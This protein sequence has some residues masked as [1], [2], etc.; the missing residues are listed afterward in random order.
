MNSIRVKVVTVL[1]LLLVATSFALQS[2][3]A[4]GMMKSSR[5][6]DMRF[7]MMARRLNLTDSQ[8][9]AIKPIYDAHIAQMRSHY[10]QARENFQSVL[11]PA[12][13]ARLHEMKLKMQEDLRTGRRIS[14]RGGFK[15]IGLT[16][17]QKAKLREMRKAGF[18][19]MKAERKAYFSRVEQ[20]LNANQQGRFEDMMAS[21]RGFR[22]GHGRF[23]RGHGHHG[24]HGPRCRGGM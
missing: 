20:H 1:S 23:G 24:H 11:T 3:Y 16:A 6:A 17:S 14:F 22:G 15:A 19:Q 10:K 9:L 4:H 12:Q 8:R 18:A 5:R 13:K 2:A 7:Q 21:H